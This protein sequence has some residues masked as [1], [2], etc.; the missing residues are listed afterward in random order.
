[1][2]ILFIFGFSKAARIV[3]QRGLAVNGATASLARRSGM[4]DFGILVGMDNS[5]LKIIGLMVE[6]SRE[7]GRELC[8]GVIDYAQERRDWEVRFLA[9]ADLDR[10]TLRTFAGFVARVTTPVIARR[11]DATQKPVVD[12]FYGTPHP[13]FAI[14]KERHESI[15]R[16]AAEHFLDRRFR[17]FAC[18]PYGSGKTSV[19]CRAAFVQRLRR[20]GRS[21]AVF[22]SDRHVDYEPDDRAVIGERFARPPDAAQLGLWLKSLPKPVAIFCT[23]DLRAWQTIEICREHG[24]RVPSDAAILGLDNDLLICGC[25]HP[26]LSSIDPN[27]REIGRVA[28][29]TLAEMI[30]R[31]RPAKPVIRQ[32][33]PR[34]V[35]ARAS[36]ETYP[37]DP[38]WLSDAL[39]YIA[40]NIARGI[41][42]TDVFAHLG[43][44]QPTVNRIFRRELGIT[45]QKAVMCARIEAAK[46]LLAATDLQMADIAR[47][48]G[49]ASPTYFMQKFAAATATT[50]SRWRARHAHPDLLRRPTP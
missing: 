24:I 34:G 41:S 21:C 7:F 39:V 3:P 48:T 13:H 32:I 40:R 49:F 45:V 31:G 20:A 26:T 4:A 37:L 42:A 22:A 15:G 23:D 5:D 12:V 28:A 44:S 50:P 14:V 11:L 9:P 27:T 35:V 47:R 19:Y 8:K 16:L 2:S 25:T 6:R 29:E 43:R 33:E 46:R 30:E 10:A 17:H 38:P 18:C 36:T 1:M